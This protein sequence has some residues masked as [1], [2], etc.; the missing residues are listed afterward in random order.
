MIIS[1]IIYENLFSTLNE[2]YDVTI[3]YFVFLT[4]FESPEETITNNNRKEGL[5][6]SV[7]CVLFVIIIIYKIVTIHQLNVSLFYS[8]SKKYW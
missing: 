4:I 5:F 3:A 6:F 7:T 2:K 8:L 1:K